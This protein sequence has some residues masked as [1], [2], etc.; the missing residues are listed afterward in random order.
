[1]FLLDNISLVDK[2]NLTPVN[3]CTILK[4]LPRFGGRNLGSHHLQKPCNFSKTQPLYRLITS[5][6]PQKFNIDTKNKQHGQSHHFQGNLYIPIILRYL[7]SFSGRVYPVIYKGIPLMAF[8]GFPNQANTTHVDVGQ[9]EGW[10]LGHSLGWCK[11]HG[12]FWLV[13]GWFLVGFWLVP[14]NGCFIMEN[15]IKMD[16]L[17]DTPV[18]GNTQIQISRWWLNQPTWKTW[19]NLDHETPRIRVKIRHIWVATTNPVSLKHEEYRW[20]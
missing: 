7:C 19:V 8:P 9:W 2:K 14:Q 20:E 16:D 18:F 3:P 15:P 1:M 6:I 4:D 11:C 12:G 17:G 13:S 10:F 5:V